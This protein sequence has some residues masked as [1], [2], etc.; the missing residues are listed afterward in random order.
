MNDTTEM[1]EMKEKIEQLQKQL[2]ATEARLSRRLRRAND[3][4]SE[5]LEII[6]DHAP[7]HHVFISNALQYF[8]LEPQRPEEK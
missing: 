4:L 8:G 1:R 5:G 3:L 6:Q 7:G 2:L